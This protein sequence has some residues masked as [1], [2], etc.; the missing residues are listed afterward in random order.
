MSILNIIKR[1]NR[2]SKF[3][4]KKIIV[5]SITFAMFATLTYFGI[6]LEVGWFGISFG[7]FVGLVMCV[8]YYFADEGENSGPNVA[9]WEILNNNF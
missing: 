9:W 1:I 3:N 8:G 4:V 6:K 7:I 5:I 2:I